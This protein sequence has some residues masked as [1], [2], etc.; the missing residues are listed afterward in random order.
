MEPPRG[1]GRLMGIP[2]TRYAMNGDLAVAYQV[3]G[4]SGPDVLIMPN[5]FSNV[6]ALWDVP[7]MRRWVEAF[8]SFARVIWFDQPG[9]GVSDP[10]SLESPPTLEQ[11]V[12]SALAVLDAAGMNETTVMA[13][14]GAFP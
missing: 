10:I 5:W 6:E 8:E 13:V 7:E 12:D 9:T 11:W 3:I 14:D 2:E 4:D 1:R